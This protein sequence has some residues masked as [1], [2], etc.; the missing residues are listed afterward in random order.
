MAVLV[1]QLVAADASA[2]AFSVDPVSGDRDLIVV[3]ATWGLGES[4]VGGLV[5][6]DS[7]RLR[8]ADLQIV[9]RQLADKSQISVPMVG[10]TQQ[11]A[12]P[13][14]RRMAPALSDGQP[15]AG[16]LG[17]SGASG[18]SEFDRPLWPPAR[19]GSS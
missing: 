10:G 2:V 13:A 19:Q 14:E 3:N 4:L 1:Q 5:T 17:A 12:L 15:L 9:A 7:Y 16:L 11:V 18:F 8:K 6:P